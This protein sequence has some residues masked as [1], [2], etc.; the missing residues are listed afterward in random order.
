M[1]SADDSRRRVET[2]F[3]GVDDHGMGVQLF[4]GHQG[5]KVVG[6]APGIEMSQD[7]T[8]PMPQAFSST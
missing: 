4:V 6:L 8:V 2:L 5:A 1:G 7:P 3:I